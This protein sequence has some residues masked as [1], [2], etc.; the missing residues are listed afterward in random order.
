M[1]VLKF[2]GASLRDANSVELV[3]QQVISQTKPC[4]VVCSALEGVSHQMMELALLA[5]RQ[6]A[7]YRTEWKLLQERHLD[8]LQKMLPAAELASACREMEQFFT[9]CLE[10][11]EGISL[12]REITPK[13][14]ALVQSFGPGLSALLLGK[15]LSLEVVDPREL[16]ATGVLRPASEVLAKAT[17][18][19]IRTRLSKLQQSVVVP[20]FIGRDP[21]GNTTNLGCRGADYTAALIASAL[22]AKV[23]ELWMDVDGFMSADPEIV[24]RTLPIEHLTY[25][26]AIELSHFGATVLYAPAIR[27]VYLKNIPVHIRNTYHP[28]AKGTVISQRPSEDGDLRIKGVSSIVDITLITIQGPTMVGVSGT[29]Q[30][31]F[32]ALARASANVILI[33]QASSEFSI[34]FAVKPGDAEASV[35]SIREEFGIA[36]NAPSDIHIL[37]EKELSVIAVVGEQMKN[38]PGI[39]ATLFQALGRNGISVIATAQGSSELNISVVIRKSA[40][41]KALNVVHEAFFITRGFKTLH[42]FQVGTGTVGHSLLMQIGQQ[43][44]YLLKEHKIKIILVGVANIDSMLFDPSGIPGAQYEE[45]L[46]QRGEPVNLDEFV[47]RIKTLNLRNSVFVDCTASAAIASKYKELL[48]NFISVVTP[49]KI[50]C[51]S[52]YRQYRE[53][54]DA[55]RE[56]GVQF[57]YETNVGAGLP[58]I[59]TMNDLIM[60]G[61]KILRIEAV[62]SGTLNFIFN[63][64][65]ESIPLSQTIRMAQEQGFSEPDPRIDLSGTDV[66]RKILILSREAGYAMEKEDVVVEKFLPDS[67]FTG[68]LEDFWKEVPRYDASFETRRK[69]IAAEN[70]RWRFVAL[71]ENGKASV[72]LRTV[73]QDHPAFNLAGSNNIILITTER[74]KELPMVTQGLWCRSRGHRCRHFCRCHPGG[75]LNPNVERS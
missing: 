68:S 2:G 25:P 69:E 61:D 32:N 3:R 58:I 73:D 13:A 60:S 36:E 40:L 75:Q 38:T 16:I 53:L 31:L 47:A 65:S 39:S 57:H 41:R 26:E 18:E 59:N 37:V 56:H 52:E 24:Q 11:F 7:S 10:L 71:L 44:A 14:R 34:T 6:D 49:N 21:E 23:L 17:E 67:C 74:Y 45:E 5:S 72:Q 9:H 20:G 66:V 8:I 55:A 42:L 15:V 43:Q 35:Q 29:S 28:K 64:I 48:S 62:L 30:R 1:K 4:V 51:S 63:T 12:I 46:A 50:A 27:P 54:K 19:T 22:N 70:K 33:T